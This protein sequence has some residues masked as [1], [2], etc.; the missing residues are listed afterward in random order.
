MSVAFEKRNREELCRR[1]QE[2]FQK[3]A[4]KRVA[5]LMRVSTKKQTTDEEDPIPVQR[6]KLL[7]MIE[8]VPDWEPAY[9]DGQL[10]EYTEVTSA[11]KVSRSDRELLNKA[12]RDAE[13][14]FYDIILLFKHDRLSRISEEYPTILR[15]FWEMGVEVWDYE[16]KQPL[17]VKSQMD[18][19][20]RFVEGWQSETESVN[21]S[22][23]VT[24]F[25]RSY[26]LEGRWLGGR[27]PYGYKYREP[28]VGEKA[29]YKGRVRKKIVRGI[30]VNPEEAKWVKLAFELYI[31]GYGSSKICEFLNNPPNSARRRN[32]R[33]FDHTAILNIIRNPIYIGYPYWGKTSCRDGY[34][35]R[36]PKEQW[37]RPEERIKKLQIIPDEIF[38]Q[39][40]KFYEE[41]SRQIKKGKKI[42]RRTFA[43]DRLLAGLA[44][45]G[46]CGEPLLSKTYS[47]PKRN[48]KREGYTCRSKKRNAPCSS[49]RG[50][51]FKEEIEEKV[52]DAVKELL[53]KLK[54]GKMEK[55]VAQIQEMYAREASEG[56]EELQTLAEEIRKLKIRQNFYVNEFNKLLTGEPT[57]LPEP[58]VRE[59]VHLIQ[60]KIRAAEAQKEEIENKINRRPLDVEMLK[61]AVLSFESWA[62]E[63]DRADMPVKKTL[64]ESIIDKIVVYDD[65]IEI[66]Y[67]L[68]FEQL[69]LLCA[70]KYTEELQLPDHLT[71]L[72][73]L[74]LLLFQQ[75]KS[76]EH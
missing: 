10:L 34:Y 53:A 69:M 43:S 12:L 29:D 22:F 73:E 64:L 13:N 7:A 65:K 67:N 54:S 52:V 40:Q 5:L 11:F 33:P 39:A 20:I 18:K 63:F 76:I 15:D 37:V 31:K 6:E 44:F 46:A 62:D 17:T 27:S 4:K 21:T 49:K 74:S 32:G 70:P 71:L 25:M 19:L 50:F 48:Y 56:Y 38:Y 35:K 57:T 24:E 66:I 59:Q 3:G 8:Q 16:K 2:R 68:D 36:L 9:R 30:E 42:A 1:K 51:W 72:G 58:V 47:A 41:R 23:R 60:E 55:V 14:D 28:M 45:C 75:Y 26:A 61:K